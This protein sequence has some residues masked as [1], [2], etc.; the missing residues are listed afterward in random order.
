MTPSPHR[1]RRRRLR[2]L[3]LR[4]LPRPRHHLPRPRHR[5]PRPRHLPR[6]H[7]HYLSLWSRQ[8]G[9]LVVLAGA[10]AITE[11]VASAQSD[12]SGAVIQRGVGMARPRHAPLATRRLV[13]LNCAPIPTGQMDA[14][15]GTAA[16][17]RALPRL[18]LGAARGRIASSAQRK[19]GAVMVAMCLATRCGCALLVR[20]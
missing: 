14:I 15:L 18:P 20:M 7:L 2:P 11:A 3:R 16:E 19:G 8:H 13:L 17:A 10:Q 4:H 12:R 5:L 1:P 6:V 9:A